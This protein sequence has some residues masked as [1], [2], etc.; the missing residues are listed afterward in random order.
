MMTWPCADTK[1]LSEQI[2]IHHQVSVAICCL[3]HRWL[4]TTTCVSGLG[5]YWFGRWLVAC[6]APSHLDQFCPGLNELTHWGWVPHIHIS[7]LT[8]IGSDNGLSPGRCQAIV[9]TN[10]VICL[11]GPLGTNFNE[12]LI[13][14]YTFSF[15]KMHLKML[16]AKWTPFCLSLNV[17]THLSLVMHYFHLTVSSLV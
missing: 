17:L 16:S 11:I 13:E 3:A 7:K 14:I 15:K 10:A 1:S 8:I 6:L 12:I 4:V 2:L 9:W 5:H